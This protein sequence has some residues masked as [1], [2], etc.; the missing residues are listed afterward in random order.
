MKEDF[1]NYIWS[2]KLYDF[3]GLSV[4][5]TGEKIKLIE[6]G[7]RNTDSGPDFFN[8]RIKIGNTIWAG[9]VE[10][11]VKSSDWLAHRHHKDEAY[12]NIILHVVYTDDKPVF[13]K[14]GE[15]IP[16][17][18]LRD[19]IDIKI[20]DRYNS[21]IKSKAWIACE[22]QIASIDRFTVFAWLEALCIERLEDKANSIREKLKDNKQDFS[23]I[24]YRQLGRNFG[25]NTNSDAFELLTK[26]LPFSLVGK[27]MDRIDQ[28]EA[29]FFGQA[30]LLKG[31][32]KDNYPQS[33][34]REYL[35][36]QKKYDLVPVETK[37][38]RFM[39]MRPSNFP[40]TR[41]SQFVH[42]LHSVSGMLNKIL[43][44]DNLN[45]LY[46]LF[47]VQANA[48]WQDHS[49]FD[50]PSKPKS[51]R[52]GQASIDIL[53]I[54][55][56]IPFTF[57]YGKIFNEENIQNKALIWYEQIK[58]ERNKIT[59][60]FTSLGLIID[61]AKHSQAVIQLKK[62]YCDK[63]RCLRCRFGHVLISGS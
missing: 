3:N 34:Y 38:W 33:L 7:S 58:P 12:D 17:V 61:N 20:L 1:I 5:G 22:N 57:I 18:E 39:R 23:E 40:T 47:D 4:S 16:T 62:N 48:Y 59:N 53:L 31:P 6:A 60:G 8:A 24:F 41:I 29:L 13:R 2:N 51:T 54:N 21:F 46:A 56:I 52:L 43:E 36:L 15:R 28:L 30:G 32:L 19:K 9:N 63:K 10:I 55:T 42:L 50:S 26:S 35:F 37:L 27:H 45:E 49:Y 44:H 14:N 25:F 11:H